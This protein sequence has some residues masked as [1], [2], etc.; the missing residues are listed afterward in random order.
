MSWLLKIGLQPV[1]WLYHYF[2]WQFKDHCW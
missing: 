2:Y 1:S